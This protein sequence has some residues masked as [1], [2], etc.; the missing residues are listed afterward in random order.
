MASSSR[1]LPSIPHIT[2]TEPFGAN[3]NGGR[4][5]SQTELERQPLLT[6]SEGAGRDEEGEDNDDDYPDSDGLY[7]PNCTWTSDQPTPP[8]GADPYDNARCNV[9][10]NIHRSVLIQVFLPDGLSG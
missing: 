4:R 6:P 2:F 7:P 8:R 9:Y 5:H 3:A 10:E 1:A